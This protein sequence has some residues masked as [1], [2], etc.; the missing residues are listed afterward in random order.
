MKRP[1]TLGAGRFCI[2]VQSCAGTL[3]ACHKFPHW[4]KILL[5]D[6]K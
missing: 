4:V 2:L 3:A 5:I 6:K 1:A